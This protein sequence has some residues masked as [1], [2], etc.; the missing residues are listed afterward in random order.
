[1]YSWFGS[2]FHSIATVIVS[3]LA[4]I[5]I[6]QG[7][8]VAYQA[9]TAHAA[10]ETQA[11]SSPSELDELRFALD[12]ER[13]A[14]LALEAR[15]SGVQYKPSNKPASIV[16]TVT[17]A[18]A[19]LDGVEQTLP[20]PPNTAPSAV[21]PVAVAERKNLT[22]EEIYARVSP[23]V[24]LISWSDANTK[25][26]GSGFVIEGGK[27]IVTNAH[28]LKSQVNTEAT[29]VNVKT[30]SGYSF[31]APIL[32]K[33]D[34][35]DIALL[36]SGSHLPPAVALGSSGESL[37]VGA[38]VYALGFPSSLSAGLTDVTFTKGTL[39]AKQQTTSWY[40]GALLQTDAAINHGNSGGP[41]VNSMGEVVGVN[42]FG[43]VD[44]QG[45]F[46]AIPIG[47]VKSQLPAL[48]QNG[49]SRNELYPITSTIDIKR[50]LL[51]QIG[52][53]SQSPCAA[54]GLTGADLAICG[55]YRDHHADYT[56]HIIEDI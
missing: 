39:S 31:D 37:N 54:L 30:K 35:L 8:N 21:L 49:Q 55:L 6:G 46:F 45:L 20:T 47:V 3:G 4:I 53:N 23:A 19:E 9:P 51:G 5:G 12:K 33:N 16:P 43:L 38:D 22:S 26:A 34:S 1:M 32:G 7:S 2:L 17:T 11:T 36:Y 42:T 44:T 10:V 41:L 48:S 18:K 29:I 50:S 27:Y 52:F 14:R 28:V 13:T 56:W 24:V 40:S 15:V 25:Y